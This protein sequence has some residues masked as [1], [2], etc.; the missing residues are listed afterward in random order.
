MS[1]QKNLNVSPYHDDFDQNKNFYR[2]L[3]KAGFPVQAR[4]LTQ[5]QS[6]IQDQIEKL[7]SRI[8]REGDNVVPGEFSLVNP[9]AYVR[10]S[11]F[12]RGSDVTEYIGYT[13]TGATSGVTADINFA[14]APTNTDDATLYV[15]YTS[16]GPNGETRTFVEGEVLQIDHPNNYTAVIGT[17]GESKPLTIINDAGRL[18]NSGPL[19]IGALFKVTAGA[20]FINGMVI[21]NEEQTIILQKY[22]NRPS[23]KVGFLVNETIVTSSEDGSLLDNSQGSNNFAAPGADRLKI[24]LDLT[25]RETPE[26]DPNFVVLAIVRQGSIVGDGSGETVKWDWLY[27]ILARR[28][29]DESGDYMVQEFQADLME[30]TKIPGLEG[31]YEADRDGLYPFI[32]ENGFR[33]RIPFEEANGLYAAKVSPGRAYVNGYPVDYRQNF[34]LYGEKA[35]DTK[36]LADQLIPVQD[37]QTITIS[38]VSG[39]PDVQSLSGDGTTR[40]FEPIRLYRNFIDGYVGQSTNAGVPLNVG[41]APWK[42]YH[43][44]ADGDLSSGMSVGGV[45]VNEVYREGKSAVVNSVNAIS[46]GTSI[47]GRTVLVCT[48]VD[49]S[50]CGVIRPRH[51][52]STGL[53]DTQDGFFGFNSTYELGLLDSVY[54]TELSTVSVSGSAIDW[55]VGDVVTGQDSGATGVVESFTTNKQLVISDVQGN[56]LEEEN[57]AQGSKVNRIIR[58]GEITGFQFTDKGTSNSQVDLSTETGLTI[59]ALGAEIT[60]TVADS[61][62]EV[63]SDRIEITN[64]GLT[65]I[66]KFPYRTEGSVNSD[67]NQ[68]INYEV[69]TIPNGVNGYGVTQTPIISGS[70]VIAKGLYSELSDVND[71]SADI[72]IQRSGDVTTTAI[73][74]GAAFSGVAGTNFLICDNQWGDPTLKLIEGDLVTFTDDAG[75]EVTKIVSFATKPVGYGELR[76][77]AFIYFTT[78]LT[79]NVSARVV[80]V[81]RVKPVGTAEDNF[82][83]ELPATVVKTLETTPESTGIEYNVFRQFVVNV[84][85]GDNS[86][87]VS[88]TNSNETFLAFE[89]FTNIT[90]AKNV[91]DANDAAGLVGRALNVEIDTTQNGGRQA[92]YTFDSAFS[93][94]LTL[95]IIAPINVT[96]AKAKRKILRSDQ[97]IDVSLADAQKEYISLGKADIFK[98]RSI[99]LDPGGRNI[100]ITKMY[101]VDNGM[102]DNIYD[103]GKV[104]LRYGRMIP[105]APLRITF[106][107]LEHTGTG[108]FFSVDS[109]TGADG[110][111]FDAVPFFTSTTGFRGVGATR[112]NPIY[113]NLRN[114]IDFRPIVNT[115]TDDPSVYARIASGRDATTATNFTTAEFGGGNAFVPRML[116]PQTNF[117]C[118]FSSY[119][120]RIDSIFIDQSGELK[121]VQGDSDEEPKRPED[122]STAIRLYDITLP[123]YT[124]NMKSV[125]TSKFEYK[126]YQMKDIAALEKRIERVEELVTLS[127]LEQAA[128]NVEV[129][130]AVTGLNRFKNGIITDSFINHSRGAT[131]HKKYQCAIDPKLGILRAPYHSDQVDLVDMIQTNAE[132]A[133]RG[134]TVNDNIV[135][136][137]YTS[138][139]WEEQPVATTT[140]NLQP[141]VVFTYVGTLDL[142]PEVDTWTDTNQRPS[143]RIQNDS[144]FNAVRDMTDEINELSIG[145]VWG[146]WNATTTTNTSTRPFRNN[147]DGNLVN[148]PAVDAQETFIERGRAGDTS[149]IGQRNLTVSNPTGRP[150]SV[151][152]T[153]ET[154]TRVRT[155]TETTYSVESGTPIRTSLGNR[156]VNVAIARTMRSRIVLFRAANLKPNTRMYAFFDGIDVSNWISIDKRETDEEGRKLMSGE[157]NENPRGFG[158]DIITDDDGV[159]TG[160]FLVP[161][162]YAPRFNQKFVGEEADSVRKLRYYGADDEFPYNRSL[163]FNTGKLTLRFTSSADNRT[164]EQEV[165]AYCEETYISN[166]MIED[167]QETILSTRVPRI[168][169][170]TVTITETETESTVSEN[171]IFEPIPVPTPDPVVIPPLTP[172]RPVVLNPLPSVTPD[173]EVRPPFVRPRPTPTP[174]E[175]PQDPQALDFLNRQAERQQ[176]LRDRLLNERNQ[177]AFRQRDPVAQTFLVSKTSGRGAREGVFLESIDVFFKTKDMRKAVQCYLVTTDGQVPT[178]KI[179]PGSMVT[180]RPRGLLKIVGESLTSDSV[181]VPKGTSIVG[182]TSGATAVMGRRMIFN[183]APSGAIGETIPDKHIGNTTYKMLL[184][185]YVGEF[186]QGEEIEIQSAPANRCTFRLAEQEFIV[187]RLE[188]TTLGQDYTTAS[189]TFSPPQLPGGVTAEGEVKISNGKVYEINVTNRGSGYTQPP[190]ATITGDGTGAGARVFCTE[191]PDR[192]AMGV[193][194]S[195]N[196]TAA[197]RFRFKNPVYLM[198]GEYYA[199]VIKSPNSLKY[200][201]YTAKMG[202]NIIGTNRR[203][204]QVIQSGSLFKSQNGGLWTEDQTQDVTF[205]INRCKFKTNTNVRVSLENKPVRLRTIQVANPIQTSASGQDLTSRVFGDNPQVVQITHPNHGMQPNDLV[206]IEGVTQDI[207]GIT[208]DTFNGV[209]TVLN[210]DFHTFTIDIGVAATSSTVG[211]GDKE[212]STSYNIPYEISTLNS[213]LLT[214][215]STRLKTFQQNTRAAGN[216]WNAARRREFVDPVNDL[217][218][219]NFRN[220]Y[221]DPGV[222]GLDRV[223]EDRFVTQAYQVEN[224]LRVKV[225]E[226][227]YWRRPMQVPSYLN[228]SYFYETMGSEPGVRNEFVMSTRNDFVSPVIDLARTTLTCTKNLIDNPKR[229]EERFGINFKT[230]TFG[231]DISAAGISEGDLI[232]FTYQL[233]NYTVVVNSVDNDS[234]QIE[235]KGKNIY[236]IKT[237]STI[238]WDNATLESAGLSEVSLERGN[239]F[240]PMY[241]DQATGSAQWISRLFEFEDPCDGIKLKLTTF[242]YH[243]WQVRV[244]YRARPLGFTGDLE[245]LE[246]RGVAGRQ[247]MPNNWKKLNYINKVKPVDPEEMDPGDWTSVEWSFQDRDKFD[248]IQFK[249]MM[250]A[251][252]PAQVPLIAD[253]QVIASE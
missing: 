21:R 22:E 53:V 175:D 170:N 49:P 147:R 226:D 130:D 218:G 80:E 11:S 137:D 70:S 159:L 88:T 31:R 73:A 174:P 253:L 41:N 205:R 155:G 83:I 229:D 23:G 87:T 178:D 115:A 10:L 36:F 228:Q 195:E 201:M 249:I 165:D 204:T 91:S 236:L 132:R 76:A 66:E 206:A 67:L 163:S 148:R 189:V 173:T 209:H 235:V 180:L 29:D 57:I 9:A 152:S 245:T 99:I 104:K 120:G 113:V 133:E 65:K 247:G 98:V 187:K 92:T 134:Y 46:R 241:D 1:I 50:V 192:P 74:R 217:A 55:V 8:F 32:P 34:Y 96:N 153:T 48:E 207:G 164:D 149:L 227:R 167:R 216:S 215:P 143:V 14:V 123:P 95:K 13:A 248:A 56:F 208:A 184:N 168:V 250:L 63:F 161:N 24:E 45:A 26:A 194:T 105:D 139:L 129:K 82:I 193:A 232:S 42:T 242:Q 35:R 78:A 43:I 166:G 214:F 142:F 230:L 69:V 131:G 233:E 213:G 221:I 244:L 71:F 150:V 81:I 108:D 25:F 114:C 240:R 111:G 157:P 196:A 200:T 177:L 47:G 251:I 90:V 85:A 183:N 68:R 106:D 169:S 62:I 122:I 223:I 210:S 54:F 89:T 39:Q 5:Q 20:Y 237:T 119:L 146:D 135:T 30:Y 52:L 171:V 112:K 102:R 212:V 7:A 17:D 101:E 199:F 145:T 246:W 179:I 219:Q 27:D 94:T 51:M 118:S 6:I 84:N 2:V 93:D 15:T 126:R 16:S 158:R 86:V 103:I 121:I 60:L 59:K 125:T 3:Y 33:D 140:I 117:G 75:N 172:D 64:V 156:V 138:E 203:L 186:I 40:A 97:V 222:V 252:N 124:F 110:V 58:A 151:T 197:T 136:L 128:V 188:L 77:K 154:T 116:L 19:G 100:N 141:Y 231:A 61:E 185:N 234:R 79:N 107:Y 211:G 28:T 38:N 225:E 181:T 239:T 162:G 238:V 37:G 202:Q 144:L 190:S 182:L 220:D 4:E 198:A 109:Y 224:A 176:R 127:I 160:A 18:V 243:R 12:T 191:G 44:I 72:A